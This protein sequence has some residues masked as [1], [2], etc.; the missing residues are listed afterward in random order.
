MRNNDDTTITYIRF[1]LAS[2]NEID[3][4]DVHAL[5]DPDETGYILDGDLKYLQHFQELH[6]VYLLASEKR[7][8]TDNIFSA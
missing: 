6:S 3:P 2:R 8:V 1:S 5:L 7:T 4:L